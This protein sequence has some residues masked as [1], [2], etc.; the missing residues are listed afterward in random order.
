MLRSLSSSSSSPNLAAQRLFF[1]YNGL[2]RKRF[3]YKLANRI[4]CLKSIDYRICNV[5]NR[6]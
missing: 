1:L 6:I 4:V 2:P 3:K 5:V